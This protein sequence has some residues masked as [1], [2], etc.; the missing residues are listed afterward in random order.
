MTNKTRVEDEGTEGE[1]NILGESGERTRDRWAPLR[2]G[3]RFLST[4]V[5]VVLTAVS[6][7]AARS[8]RRNHSRSELCEGSWEWSQGGNLGLKLQQCQ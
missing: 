4:P 1:R 3:D 2:P 7:P 5:A 8:G 6:D